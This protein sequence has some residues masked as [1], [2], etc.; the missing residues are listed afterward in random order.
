MS[1]LVFHIAESRQVESRKYGSGLSDGWIGCLGCLGSFAANQKDVQKE[2][3]KIVADGKG[4][5]EVPIVVGGRNCTYCRWQKQFV[6]IVGK[7]KQLLVITEA[8]QCLS[9]TTVSSQSKQIEEVQFVED[10]SIDGAPRLFIC[11]ADL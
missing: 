9:A 4:L 1:N 2:A 5:A 8:I 10:E 3:A 6:P 11:F 7:G